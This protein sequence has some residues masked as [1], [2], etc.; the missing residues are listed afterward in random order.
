MVGANTQAHPVTADPGAAV[1]REVGAA[2]V[3]AAAVIVANLIGAVV[4]ALLA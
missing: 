4:W 2:G 3:I 1:R